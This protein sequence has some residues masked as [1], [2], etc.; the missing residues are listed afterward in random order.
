MRLKPWCR[1]IRPTPAAQGESSHYEWF[2]RQLQQWRP[3]TDPG[4][5]CPICGAVEPS[6]RGSRRRPRG[7]IPL[8][9][10]VT[11]VVLLLLLLSSPAGGRWRWHPQD[12]P[13]LKP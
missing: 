12:G 6:I 4:H 5:R 10:A 13:A 7:L 8:I 3:L 1:H 11:L 2:D 9:L